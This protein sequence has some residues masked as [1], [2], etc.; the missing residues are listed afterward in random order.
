MIRHRH[1][2]VN[3]AGLVV[4]YLLLAPGGWAELAPA[5]AHGAPSAPGPGAPELAALGPHPVGTVVETVPL[6]PRLTLSPAGLASG[7]LTRVERSLSLRIWYPATGSG[8]GEAVHYPSTFKMGDAVS[9][10]F[11]TPGIAHADAPALSGMRLPLLVFSHGLG[12]DQHSMTYLTENLASKGYVVAAIDHRDRP[13]Q[14]LADRQLA[15][16]NVVLNRAH[17]QR[18]VIRFLIERADSAN[19]GYAAMIDV[20]A[21]GLLGYSMGGFG[22]LGT[23]GAGYGSA[24]PLLQR[25]PAEALALLQTSD[26]AIAEAIDAVV[27]IAPWGGQAPLRVWEPQALAEIEAP[28]LMI[29]GDQ[30]DVV[31]YGDGARWIFEHLSGSDRRLL[32]YRNAR[33]N[34]AN[35][36]PP[37]EALRTYREVEYYAEPVWR[38]ERLNAINQHFVSAFFD[39]TLKGDAAMS[40]YLDPPTTA[41]GDGV[42]PLAPGADSGAAT[43]AA[44]QAQFWRGFQRRWALGMDFYH[45]PRAAH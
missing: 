44:E 17:D 38:T 26:A 24:S 42:W 12:G 37:R 35:N 8:E 7:Q 39:H 40:I 5:S 9:V 33:H 10:P 41:S 19:A 30:D 20:E 27:T 34:I 18:E 32:V 15:F 1:K 3:A 16:A 13:E 4:Y 43:A 23:A 36:L 29:V 28:L 22:A 6:A 14:P 2:W 45:E 31:G 25:L 11:D 21:I